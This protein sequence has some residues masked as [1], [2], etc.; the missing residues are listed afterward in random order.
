MS[1]V[2]LCNLYFGHCIL[3][4]SNF[5]FSSKGIKKKKKKDNRQNNPLCSHSLHQGL[6]FTYNAD[7]R[8]HEYIV[9]ARKKSAQTSLLHTVLCMTTGGAVVLGS[10]K[11][12][13]KPCGCHKWNITL[14]SFHL[15]KT[16]GLDTASP[17]MPA[18]PDLVFSKYMAM[19]H[20]D[21]SSSYFLN[22]SISINMCYGKKSPQHKIM[23]IIHCDHLALDSSFSL[24]PLRIAS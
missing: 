4:L 19:K 10:I 1:S 20:E 8:L 24:H 15:W 9:W 3:G 23:H 12:P 14:M 16:G 17:F 11:I 18:A 5:R 7:D 21:N 2:L 13:I 22:F 6:Y